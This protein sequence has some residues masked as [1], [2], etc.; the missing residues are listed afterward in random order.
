MAYPQRLPQ[1]GPSRCT[2]LEQF[3]PIER[4][5][6]EPDLREALSWLEA[7]VGLVQ[8]QIQ[9]TKFFDDRK[10]GHWLDNQA[11]PDLGFPSSLSAQLQD[12][13]QVESERTTVSD[14]RGTAIWVYAQRER[15]ARCNLWSPA[16]AGTQCGLVGS[17]EPIS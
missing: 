16:G 10:V 6:L 8:S 5:V 4:H 9:V 17:V 12:P 15:P 14:E 11:H 3:C 1:T 2:T 7:N 13:I